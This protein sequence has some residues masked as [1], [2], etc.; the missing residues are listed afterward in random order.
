MIPRTMTYTILFALALIVLPVTS[1]QAGMNEHSYEVAK[2]KNRGHVGIHKRRHEFRE[3]LDSHESSDASSIA[4][5]APAAGDVEETPQSD[6]QGVS[7]KK[8]PEYNQ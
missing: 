4:S 6:I 5:I 1:I 2:E 3:H 7:R 8:F